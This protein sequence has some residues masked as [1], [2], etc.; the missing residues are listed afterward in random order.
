MTPSAQP[1]GKRNRIDKRRVEIKMEGSSEVSSKQFMIKSKKEISHEM[2]AERI[3][4]FLQGLSAIQ[5]Q[6]FETLFQ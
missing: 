1:N 4:V 5:K 3:G 2:V 6:F